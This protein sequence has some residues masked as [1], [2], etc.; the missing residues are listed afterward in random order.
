MNHRFYT[1]LFPIFGVLEA[2]P[3]NKIVPSVVL[4]SELLSVASV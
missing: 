2:K 3:D 1:C 4:A